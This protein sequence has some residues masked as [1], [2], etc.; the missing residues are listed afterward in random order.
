MRNEDLVSIIKSHRKDSLGADDGTLSVER[1]NALDRYHG[2][3]YGNE[4]EGRSAVVSKDLAETVGWA[5]PA[6]MR[7]FVQSGNIGEFDPVGPEDEELA[8]QE[9]DAVNQVVMKENDGFIL[10]HDGFKDALLLRNGYWKHWWEV[11]EKISEEEYQG[12]TLEELTGMMYRFQCDGA[13]VEI[14]GQEERTAHLEIPMGKQQVQ[15]F[16]VRLKITRKEGKCKVVAV[17][18]EEVRVSRKCRGSLQESPFVEHVTRKTRSDLIELGIPKSFVNTLPSVA[19]RDNDTEALARDSISDESE[20]SDTAFADRSMDEIEYCEAFLRV[21]WDGDGIAELRKVV[22]C[23]DRIPPGSE[24]N[25]VIDAIPLTGCVPGRIPHRHVGE[26]LYDELEDL[27]EIKTVLIRQLLDNVYLTN[28]NQWVV[29]DRANIPDFLT[30]LP[31]GIKRMKGMDPVSGSFEALQA[32]PIVG[33][34]LPVIDYIDKLKQ[35]RSGVSE[36]TTGLD[37]DILKQSTKGAFIENLNRAS[38]KIEMIARML[39]ETGVKPL[40][41]QVHSILVKHQDKPKMMR[42]RGKFVSVNPQEWRD[43]TDLTLRVGLGTGSGEEQQQ[44]L[45]MIAGAQEKLAM[46]GM[47]GPRQAYALFTDLCKALGFQMPEKYAVTPDPEN[48][49]FQQMQQQMGSKKDPLVQAEEVKAQ[50]G[51]QKAQIDA[52]TKQ[53]EIQAKAQADM[54]Q[55]Q[56][57]SSNDVAIEREKIAA[58]MELE[59]FKAQIAAE[60][61]II[62]ER[63]RQAT[64]MQAETM[65]AQ[66]AQEQAVM[67]AQSA[68]VESGARDEVLATA[69]EGL[70]AAIEKVGGPKKIKRDASGRAEGIE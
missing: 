29:N 57:R 14:I 31:G 15:V 1:A 48:P 50:A 7:V 68:G 4:D 47:V 35:G 23:A 44:K 9:S 38:Q 63:M 42:L 26:S 27:Q 61:E 43:R 21:D 16:D 59:R 41:L 37:P 22:T 36:T 56:I 30:S 51:L 40:L 3:P 25:E 70:R 24:W 10:L 54:Q 53:G 8:A 55:E 19:N 49:E 66:Q 65:R 67:A 6:I 60:T 2:R 52:Q 45:M 5:M 39:A 20:V 11:T 69:L 12:L 18:T 64:A 58:Q 13:E 62:V 34:V 28:N 17:P 46:M 32:V 33:Q